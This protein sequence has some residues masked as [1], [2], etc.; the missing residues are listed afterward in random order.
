MIGTADLCLSPNHLEAGDRS[1]KQQ[2]S[3]CRTEIAQ[4]IDQTVKVR[5]V[6]DRALAEPKARVARERLIEQLAQG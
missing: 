3:T 1:V 6:D 5:L 4:I 2:R